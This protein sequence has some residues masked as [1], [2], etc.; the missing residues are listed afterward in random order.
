MTSYVEIAL[1]LPAADLAHPAFGKLF[2]ETEYLAGELALALSPAPRDPAEAALGAARPRAS[3]DGRRARSNGRPIG[4]SSSGAAAA[5]DRPRRSTAAALGDHG[6]VL[7]PI[8]SLRQRIRLPPGGPCVCPLRPE[9]RTDRDAAQALAQ[10]YRDPSGAMR[11]FALVAPLIRR[12]RCII[13]AISSEE[14]LLFDRLASRVLFSDG[15]LRAAA[16]RLAANQLGKPGLWRHSI[17]GDLPILLV[18]VVEPDDLP[19][20]R[21][22]L[23]AQEYW[24]LKGLQADVVIL[25]EQPAATG[26]DT[27]DAADR[28]ARRGPWRGWRQRPGGV[29]LLRGDDDHRGRA[30]AAR[31]GG[32]CRPQ[33][34]VR[35]PAAQLD[36]PYARELRSRRW[37]PR[38]RPAAP[39][40]VRA[41][42]RS[43]R[44]CRRSLLANGLGGF[45]DD[46]PA[47]VIVL[48][49]DQ[50][51][52]PP[53]ANVLAN[54][55]FGTIVTASG[56]A[57]TWAENSRENRLTPFANDP[58]TDPTAEAWFI[59]DDET[60]E[61]WSPTPGP[62]RRDKASG[63]SS[64][65]MR[66]A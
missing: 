24:R 63:R 31:G 27:H 55:G 39:E 11:A 46:G 16:D 61:I 56:S 51:T 48:E 2:I 60:G 35:R 23:Q 40:A 3:K 15:S 43:A 13:S 32:A 19:L 38:R 28:A 10:K 58:V 33:R 59:R 7:D 49:G 52:P 65:A 17:S 18:R 29:F 54:P 57:H 12:A 34:R 53:W 26:T 41:D 8:L 42:R 9:W 22:V 30:R 50:E 64:F 14:A 45:A 6:V 21:Q 5:R 4:R 36:R 20:V 37:S 62:F 47:Y 1:A 66:P 44:R 25:N